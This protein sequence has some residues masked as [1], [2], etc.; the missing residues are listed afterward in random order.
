MV[1]VIS[2]LFTDNYSIILVKFVITYCSPLSITVD[3]NPPLIRIGTSLQSYHTRVRIN[4]PDPSGVCNKFK[5][6]N[7]S[8]K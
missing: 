6:Y 4:V 2:Q 5:M 3:L 8:K 7:N 1:I